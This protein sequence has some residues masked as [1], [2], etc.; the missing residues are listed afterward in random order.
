MGCGVGAGISFSVLHVQVAGE[1]TAQ[2]ILL[3][4]KKSIIQINGKFIFI[5]NSSICGG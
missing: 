4:K 3:Q 2:N 1:E 5:M